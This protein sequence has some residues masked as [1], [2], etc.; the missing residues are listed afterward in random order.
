MEM[1][2]TGARLFPMLAGVHAPRSRPSSDPKAMMW[3]GFID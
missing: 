3:K 1:V 2:R